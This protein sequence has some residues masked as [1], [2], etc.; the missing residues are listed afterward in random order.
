MSRETKGKKEDK[1]KPVMTAKEKRTAKR[2]KRG[3]K[4]APGI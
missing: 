1:K 2:A 3:L 4:K